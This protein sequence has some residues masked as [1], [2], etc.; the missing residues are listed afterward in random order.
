MACFEQGNEMVTEPIQ[1]ATI[2]LH[3]MVLTYQRRGNR[4]VGGVW[5]VRPV[6]GHVLDPKHLPSGLA[7]AGV[8]QTGS[9]AERAVDVEYSEHHG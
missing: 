4:F 9:P 8:I 6:G 1:K 5:I 7:P 2:R 3:A